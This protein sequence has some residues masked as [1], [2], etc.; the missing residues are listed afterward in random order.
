[1][2]RRG[3]AEAEGE[4]GRV[5]A[6][7]KSHRRTASRGR[8]GTFHYLRNLADILHGPSRHWLR[9]GRH[10]GALASSGKHRLHFFSRTLGVPSRHRSRRRFIPT[11]P[12]TFGGAA[13][14]A[15]L[16]IVHEWPAGTA[17]ALTI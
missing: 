12:S 10:S 6:A 8:F 14:G 3:R 7:C 17:C 11:F 16:R 4:G 9:N 1:M 15:A 2:F 13:S 5:G